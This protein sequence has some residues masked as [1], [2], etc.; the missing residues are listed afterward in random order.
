MM[1][2]ETGIAVQ[3]NFGD[4]EWFCVFCGLIVDFGYGPHYQFW[5]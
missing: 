1:T 5:R 4:V 3:A 2:G